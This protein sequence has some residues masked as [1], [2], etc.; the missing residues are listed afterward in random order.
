MYELLAGVAVVA[1]SAAMAHSAATAHSTEPMTI[2]F[3]HWNPHLQCFSG[4]PD[5]ASNATAALDNLMSEKL[6]FM[7]VVELESTSYSPPEGWAAIA[8]FDS[9]GRG[10]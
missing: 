3:A 10:R 6:D 7:N 1:H 4:H 5:C 2:S 8:A 9:C